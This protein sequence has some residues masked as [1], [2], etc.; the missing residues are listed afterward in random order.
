MDKIRAARSLAAS[1]W[2]RG[3]N[4]ATTVMLYLHSPVM[5]ALMISAF[6]PV[7]SVSALAFSNQ[8]GQQE[9]Q[10]FAFS[11]RTLWSGTAALDGL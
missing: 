2:N 6:L 1:T 8:F 4:R 3:C 5:S 10:L 7:L 9:A 11:S